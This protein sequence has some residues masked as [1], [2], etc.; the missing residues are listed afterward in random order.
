MPRLDPS[1]EH[2]YG[3]RPTM[4]S[5]TSNRIEKRDMDQLSMIAKVMDGNNGELRMLRDRLQ[6]VSDRMFTEVG[7]ASETN[8]TSVMKSRERRPG[9]T[10]RLIYNN[11]DCGD[12]I[13][14]INRI[15]LDLE[16]L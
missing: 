8:D 4:G 5:S 12:V 15:V 16:Q 10:G 14:Q 3:S 1:E 7:E 6:V 9:V 13:S 2:D 11:E